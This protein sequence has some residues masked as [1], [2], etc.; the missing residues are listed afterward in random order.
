MDSNIQRA[1]DLLPSIII[2]V[3]SMIQA[4]ALELF[5]SRIQESEFLWEGGWPATIGWVQLAVVLLGI[6]LIWVMYVSLILRFSWLPSME[7]T[8][9]P[10]VIGLLEFSLIDLMGPATLGPWFCVLAAA[11]GISLGAMHMAHHQARRDPG[12]SYF[13]S[14]V[15]PANW[16]D[17]VGSGSAI[18]VLLGFGAALWLTG[19]S[20]F[21]ALAGLSFAFVVFGH[22]LLVGRSYWMHTL[23]QPAAAAGDGDSQG[24]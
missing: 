12:N 21:L 5:W 14:Q 9:V 23:V 13:F 18:A 1:R 10:F 6:L 22:Q 2:T 20:G 19:D 4:L 15:S 11:F 17:Y 7:D 16:R 8:I 24:E 3:L